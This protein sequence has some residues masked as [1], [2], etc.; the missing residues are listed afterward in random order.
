[1][2]EGQSISI[3]RY[4]VNRSS[5]YNCFFADIKTIEDGGNIVPLGQIAYLIIIA[6]C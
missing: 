2:S 3:T 6:Q 1:M 4:K 5:E